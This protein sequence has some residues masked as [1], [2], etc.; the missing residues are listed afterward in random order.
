M[1]GASITRV[2]IDR[3]AA[4]RFGLTA[5]DIDNALYDAFGQRQINEIQTET[6]QYKIILEL[7]TAQR[8]DADE[9]HVLPA[10]LAGHR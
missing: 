6:N 7:S 3:A 1:L 9:P 5:S 10:A 4:A 8:G 2:A